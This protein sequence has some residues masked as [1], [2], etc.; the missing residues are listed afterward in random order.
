MKFREKKYGLLAAAVMSAVMILA[1]LMGLMLHTLAADVA[2]FS[3]VSKGSAYYDDIC[4]AEE[5]GIV[6]GYNGK[7]DPE[8]KVTLLQFYTML[9]RS[10]QQTKI[11]I[12]YRSTQG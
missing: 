12:L 2:A 8:G 3:D 7:F 5:N 4:W 10:I 9:S 1:L 6:T 11:S